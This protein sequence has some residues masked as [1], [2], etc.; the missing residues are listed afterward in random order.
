MQNKITEIISEK[1]IKKKVKELAKQITK[2]YEGESIVLVC[3]LKGGVFFTC[4]LARKIDLE[5][6]LD[7]M[8]ISSYGDESESSGVVR[9]VKDL[10]SSITGKNV[11]IVEDII[12]SGNT[13][14]YLSKVLESRN[15]KSLKICTLLDKPSRREKSVKIDYKGFDV[16]DG[17]VVGYGLDY[18][19]KNRALPYIAEIE[20]KGE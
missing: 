20:I 13:L 10:D 19:G 8:N 15:P 9:I 5:V 14:A 7:F 18:A 6:S 2:D 17:F 11:L 1:K 16:K 4:D 3:I 12:D